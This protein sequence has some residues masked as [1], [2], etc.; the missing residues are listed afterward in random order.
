MRQPPP[1]I[2]FLV[3]EDWYFCLHRLPI[4]RAARDAGFRVM[5]AT[6]VRDHGEVLEREGFELIPMRWT[7]GSLN[8]LH[9]LSELRQIIRI[10]RDYQPDLV[11][12][13][14][15]R[16]SIYGSIAAVLTG[17]SPVVNN[18]AGLG[19]AFSSSG[20]YAGLVRAI[21]T[22]AF[23]LLFGRPGNCTVVENSDDRAFLINKVGL[24]A[25]SVI[26]IRGIGV[27]IRRFAP[28]PERLEGVPVVTLVSRMLW[29]KG[30]GELVEAAR[31][32]RERGVAVKVRLVGMPDTTS[33]VSIP[34]R[35]LAHW[36]AEGVVEWLGYRDDIP[37]L[38]RTSNLAVLPSYY[39]E[40]VPRSLLE[41]AA[42]GRAIV[43]TDMPGCREIVQ[44][45]INGL[46]VPPRDAQAIADAI[47][48]LVEDAALRQRMG[49]AGRALVEK[50]FSEEYTVEQTL[51]VYRRLV[52]DRAAMVST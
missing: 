50:G 9:T 41:A 19:L 25:D 37:E 29:P 6:Q 11:H 40:G 26:L 46:L 20:V 30:I 13:V 39:R 49:A 21:V 17:V 48:Q 16:P 12:H 44:H 47:Q 14:A 52:E 5:V 18:L 43:T 28:T 4:A 34:E 15:L 27:D 7:R 33:R 22:T 36:N 2:L 23:R 24:D 45:G 8:P 38:W 42:C 35:Q 3:T 51:A 10:Y 31:I 32:L 1:G